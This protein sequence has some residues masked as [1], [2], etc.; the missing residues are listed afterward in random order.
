MWYNKNKEKG[1]KNPNPQSEKKLS[2]LIKACIN[3]GADD[4][5]CITKTK[6][7]KLVYL[8]DF[9]YYYEN[10]K[11]ITGVT[12]TKM[13]RGPVAP[14]YF[15]QLINLVSNKEIDIK[16]HGRAQLISLNVSF[17]KSTLSTKEI[18]VVK[19]ICNKWKNKETSQIVKFTHEQLPWK[20]SFSNQEVPYS[21]IIQQDEDKLY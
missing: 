11:P 3:F 20:I 10:L 4:D 19:K 17:D 15:D 9:V 6:L 13:A 8:A 21:L 2:K 18:D 16:P 1:M 7:A 5:G 12:Y 14:E